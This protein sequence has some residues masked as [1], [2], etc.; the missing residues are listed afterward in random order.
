MEKN[1]VRVAVASLALSAAAFVGITQ[2]ESFTAAA[3][4]P[5]KGDVPTYGFGSTVKE[6]GSRV[7]M[8]DTITPVK[9]VRLTLKH[10]QGDEGKLR[11]CLG[12]DVKLYQA[13]WDIYVDLAYNIGF[14]TFC[15]NKL[16]GGPGVIPKALQEGNYVAACQ[17]ILRYRYAAGYDCATLIN[18]QPNKRCWG[19]W[20]DRQRIYKSCMEAQ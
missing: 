10:I 19:L 12:E 16:T 2:R 13:E 8:G 14:Y 6:D 3:V 11:E 15:T 4:I 1:S 18:G 20:A 7:Q 9:A 5:T 17:G